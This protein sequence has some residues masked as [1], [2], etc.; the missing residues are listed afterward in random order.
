MR[1]KLE[2]PDI[3]K[4]ASLLCSGAR[5]VRT[6]YEGRSVYFILQGENLLHTEVSYKTGSLKVNPLEF[7]IH[8]NLLRDLIKCRTP[9]LLH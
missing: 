6:R 8:L 9:Q 2:T 4:S 3:F 7:R 1:E 5:L